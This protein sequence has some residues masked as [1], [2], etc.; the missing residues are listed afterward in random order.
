VQEAVVAA[1]VAVAAADKVVAVAL[2]EA[3]LIIHC[4]E[5]ML[6]RLLQILGQVEV[7]VIILK[8]ATVAQEL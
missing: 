8:A 3:A 4:T 6:F 7:V 1:A 5:L 2:A